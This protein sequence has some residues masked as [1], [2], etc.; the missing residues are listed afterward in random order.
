MSTLRAD[1]L[2]RS[3]AKA[4]ARD[5]QSWRHTACVYSCPAALMIEVKMKNVRSSSLMQW[6]AVCQADAMHTMDSRDPRT[7][8]KYSGKSSAMFSRYTDQSSPS[9]AWSHPMHNPSTASEFAHAIAASLL[10]IPVTWTVFCAWIAHK[11]VALA[12][13]FHLGHSSHH[14]DHTYGLCVHLETLEAPFNTR[15]CPA[16]QCRGDCSSIGLDL[17]KQCV[18]G[19]IFTAALGASHDRTGPPTEYFGGVREFNARGGRHGRRKGVGGGG[20]ETIKARGELWRRFGMLCAAS[21][22]MCIC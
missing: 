2:R 5:A 18:A 12:W 16:S 1:K 9:H 21:T 13:S 19:A 7:R 11:S 10:H 22:A 17:H 6:L 20:E 14:G 4:F 8:R 15:V 3:C